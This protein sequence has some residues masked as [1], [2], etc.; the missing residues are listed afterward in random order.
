MLTVNT[1]KHLNISD[2]LLQLLQKMSEVVDPTLLFIL[3]LLRD[4]FYA[5]DLEHFV[6]MRHTYKL[7]HF[8][9]YF[10]LIAYCLKT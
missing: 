4:D 5:L 3:H 2:V 1:N 9:S 10:L 8:I 7:L 6:Q